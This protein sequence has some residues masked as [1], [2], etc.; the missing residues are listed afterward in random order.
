[1]G[2]CARGSHNITWGN[3][4]AA[5]EGSNA[6]KFWRTR[7]ARDGGVIAI[8]LQEDDVIIVSYTALDP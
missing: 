6:S 4:T 7:V 5:P 8:V 1:M 2:N 3:S